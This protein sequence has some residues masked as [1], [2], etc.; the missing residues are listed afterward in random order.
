[1]P[2]WS[3]PPRWE[4]RIGKGLQD[5]AKNAPKP[6]EL[7]GEEPGGDAGLGA[8]GQQVA[9]EGQAAQQRLAQ[10]AAQEYERASHLLDAPQIQSAEQ[11][12]SIRPGQ[13][14]RSPDGKLRYYPA[15]AR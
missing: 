9:A 8:L 11:L 2:T 3:S 12:T 10:S 13:V 4:K 6:R 5:F 15:F 1:L 14:F 7:G